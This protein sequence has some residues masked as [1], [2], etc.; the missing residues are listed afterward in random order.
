MRARWLGRVPYREA[1]DLQ[2]GLAGRSD[3]DYL[4]LLE[5]P[6]VYTLGRHADESHVLVDPSTVGAEVVRVDRG[7]D[8]TFHGPG[9]LVGYPIRSVGDG[10]HQGVV[11][12][13][14]VETVVID[15]LVSLGLPADR[16]GRLEGY[17]G[18]WTG[19]HRSDPRLPGGATPAGPRKICAVGVRTSRGRT[20]HGFALNVSHRPRHVRPHRALR[21]PR[22]A[23]HLARGRGHR[24]LDGGNRRRRPRRRRPDVGSARGR[25]TCRRRPRWRGSASRGPT[26]RGPAGPGPAGR[27]PYRPAGWRAGT[28]RAAATR[29]SRPRRGPAGHRTQT[30]VAARRRRGR[31]TRS[32]VSSIGSALSAW[33]PSATRRAVRTSTSAGR[34]A[35]P[36]S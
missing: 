27:G 26:G 20:T 5:H 28:R 33:S 23:H 31:A 25:P 32:S 15:A 1:W 11:H 19:L 12:V 3:H 2:R 24:R 7:G 4:L 17:P 36:P 30:P 8:V 35:P 14:E 18:V 34:P 6:P 10:P 21:D 16:V 22:Q 13:R 9:Q 29:R